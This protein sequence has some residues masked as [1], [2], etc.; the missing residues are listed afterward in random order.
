MQALKR[1]I[2]A[3]DGAIAVVAIMAAFVAGV[4]AW[5]VANPI[6]YIIYTIEGT[7]YAKGVIEQVESSTVAWDD[8]VDRNLGTQKLLVRITSGEH[9]GQTV[10]IT[11]DLA[12]THNVEASEGMAVVVKVDAPEGSVEPFYS[13]FNYD[14]TVPI[15]AIL[16]L[17]AILMV[18]VGGKKGVKSL[19]GLVFSLFT[20]MAFLLP[21][22]YHG[23][24]PIAMG[25]V[26]ALVITVLNMV[27]L[28]G[29]S[30]KTAAAIVS[31]MSG[32]LA[33]VV[34]YLVFSSV[35]R[36][37]GYN[38]DQAE[39]LLAVHSAT[40]LNVGEIMFVGVVISALGAVMD[41]CM[42]VATSLFEMA[43][44]HAGM[45]E[46]QVVRSG[47]TIGRDMIGTMC[48]T[49]ILAFAGTA[50]A[51]LLVMVAFG[52]QLDTLLASDFVATELLQSLIGGMAVVLSVPITAVVSAHALALPE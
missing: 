1:F 33:A 22:I 21:A 7:S 20:I 44:L 49:L 50:I 12:A 43:R 13:V 34:L 37:S 19:I 8:S 5:N 24:S 29:P 25:C 32:V 27:L 3:A 40:G 18:A 17:F 15:A 28:N 47:L 45:D 11:N 52:A 41:M 10:E 31:T 9:A 30:R 14:R 51:S 39:E 38:L 35:M 4:L 42:S 36:L 16:G 2:S 26:T 6:D 48:M 46:R 23:A